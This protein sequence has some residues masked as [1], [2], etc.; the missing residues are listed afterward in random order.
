MKLNKKTYNGM[1][2]AIIVICIVVIGVTALVVSDKLGIIHIWH[3]EAELIIEDVL[4]NAENMPAYENS[5]KGKEAP[6]EYDKLLLDAADILFGDY[7]WYGKT[8][9][10]KNIDQYIKTVEVETEYGVEN[11]YVYSIKNMSPDYIVAVKIPSSDEYVVVYN[12]DCTL[13][14]NLEYYKESRGLKNADIYLSLGGMVNKVVYDNIDSEYIYST[15]LGEN[16]E[17]IDK[18]SCRHDESIK[19]LGITIYFVNK[20]INENV[21]LFINEDGTMVFYDYAKFYCEFESDLD[22]TT[23]MLKYIVNNYEGYRVD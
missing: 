12:C 4:S 17:C 11:C 21:W 20:A 15:Y 9:D 14:N 1:L 16:N 3:S 13:I 10:S 18:Y 6:G 22:A 19:R 7:A 8:V 2:I 5:L 23:E